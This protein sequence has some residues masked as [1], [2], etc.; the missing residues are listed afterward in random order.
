MFVGAHVPT[1]LRRP[2]A[3]VLVRSDVCTEEKHWGPAWNLQ[4]FGFGSLGDMF[5]MDSH[6]YLLAPRVPSICGFPILPR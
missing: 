3:G 2:G 6:L 4:A 5:A 1:K